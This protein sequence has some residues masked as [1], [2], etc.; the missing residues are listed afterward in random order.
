MTEQPNNEGLTADERLELIEKIANLEQDKANLTGEI[1]DERKKKQEIAEEKE[2]LE[3]VL[4]SNTPGDKLEVEDVVKKILDQKSKEELE[5]TRAEVEDEFLE[6]KTEFKSSNDVGG[7]KKA[8]FKKEL[9]KFNLSGLK[10]RK[11]L[12]ERFE[13]VYR[14]MQKNGNG[15]DGNISINPSTP[16]NGNT[17]KPTDPN[18]FSPQEL[19][20]MKRL[21]WTSEQYLKTKAKRPAYVQ[22]I[23]AH[24]RG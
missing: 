10:S 18:S 23:F 16:T 17:V 6:S 9:A 19:D 2:K 11:A 8:A 3:K 22:S 7:L 1:Q 24:Y 14:F 20:V 12:E 4:K 15:G 21:G 5:Y 13:E